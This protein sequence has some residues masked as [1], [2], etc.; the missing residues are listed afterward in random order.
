MVLGAFIFFGALTFLG[1]GFIWFYVPETSRLTLEE[2]DT[3]F[4]ST[5]L[6]K[7]D[8]DRMEQIQ[9][10]VGLT[11]LIHGNSQRASDDEAPEVQQANE[12]ATDT[13]KAV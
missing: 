12:K 5:G 11:A 4:G 10:E 8:A 9:R 13:F 2:M 6:A 7:S 3:I 1:A